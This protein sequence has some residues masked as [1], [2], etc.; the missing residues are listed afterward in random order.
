MQIVSQCNPGCM[1]FEYSNQNFLKIE[2]VCDET[3]Y[4]IDL[5][6]ILAKDK[7]NIVHSI[8]HPFSKLLLIMYIS[9]LLNI[10]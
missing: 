7:T 1:F 9:G 8:T 10:I 6:K 5:T 3:I 2:Q 4:F